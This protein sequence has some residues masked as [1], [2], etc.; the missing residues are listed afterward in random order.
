ML[1]LP[2]GGGVDVENDQPFCRRLKNHQM[3]SQYNP[4][5]AQV[6]FCTMQSKN[7]QPSHR[8]QQKTNHPPRRIGSGGIDI[9]PCHAKRKRE[10]SGKKSIPKEVKG[11]P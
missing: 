1:N 2:G 5:I 3:V 6:D 4:V 10:H 8:H 9:A 7:N 11:I